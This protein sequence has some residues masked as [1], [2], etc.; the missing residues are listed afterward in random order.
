MRVPQGSDLGPLLFVIDTNDLSNSLIH[1]KCI[2]FAVD[3][4]IYYAAKNITDIYFK[5]NTDLTDLSEWLK[6]NKLTLNISKTNYVIFSK[7]TTLR[8]TNLAQKSE[9]NTSPKYHMLSS[10]V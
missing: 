2:L 4:T 9:L 1:S 7:S 8:N 5:L 3:T 10:C 6:A